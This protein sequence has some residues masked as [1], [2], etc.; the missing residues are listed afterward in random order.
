MAETS[1]GANAKGND[2]TAERSVTFSVLMP[3][4]NGKREFVDRAVQS[5]LTQ[6]YP[7]QE[8]VIV[9]DGSEEWCAAYLDELACAD[10][11]VI[12]LHAEH[13]G[14][15]HARNVGLLNLHGT[16]VVFL[17]ADDELAPGC[18]EALASSFGT[19]E[20]DVIYFGITCV[21]ANGEVEVWGS[22]ERGFFVLTDDELATMPGKLLSGMAPDAYPRISRV[23]AGMPGTAYRTACLGG[24]RFNERLSYDEDLL[25]NIEA[26]AAVTC[27]GIEPR[28]FY[29]YSIVASSASHRSDTAELPGYVSQVLT[30][31][32]LL[33]EEN[34]N[35]EMESARLLEGML[36]A[37]VSIAPN[38]GLLAVWRRTRTMCQN[39]LV[40]PH[41][42]GYR[43]PGFSPV[44][45]FRAILFPLLAKG[46]YFASAC[47]VKI[48]T[49]GSARLKPL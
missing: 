5:V 45:R 29:R 27:A 22:P 30:V 35:P 48:K 1:M 42:V 49:L 14:V 12:V 13:G 40:R 24:M 41:L 32:K 26:L 38:E 31:F 28:P 8:L 10:D 6:S 15:S 7:C 39:E 17:D 19:Y 2:G 21:Y 20:V 25:F 18:L 11:K 47:V 36:T 23:F 43:V 16:H 44:G 3:V 4:Y 33:G 46:M 9:D 34:R 37:L